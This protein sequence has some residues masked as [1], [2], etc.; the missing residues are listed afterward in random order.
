MLL[1]KMWSIYFV[2]LWMKIRVSLR[3]KS[4][5]VGRGLRFRGFPHLEIFPMAKISI[6]DNVLLNSW[7]VGYHL[8]MFH[9]V[10]I[11]LHSNKSA[12]IIGDNTRIHGTCIHVKSRVSIGKNCLIAANT[13]IFDCNGHPTAMTNPESRLKQTDEPKPIVIQDNVWIGTGCI[14]LP[15]TE[16]GEGSIIGAGSVVNGT[17]PAHSIAKGNPA[18][19]IEN[20]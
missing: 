19:V 1:K 6:G 16:I 20:K 8:S 5:K 10:K 9:P 14:I 2:N 18:V 12:L 4:F 17:I 3:N 15:G 11:L 13:Q 7:N